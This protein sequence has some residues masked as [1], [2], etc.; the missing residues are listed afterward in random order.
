MFDRYMKTWT[1]HIDSVSNE[2]NKPLQGVRDSDS[3]GVETPIMRMTWMGWIEVLGAHYAE[4]TVEKSAVQLRGKM[5][6]LGFSDDHLFRK[7]YVDF[8]E[9]VFIDC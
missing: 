3:P 4:A 9:G 5:L 7:T 8:D 6:D 1:S 2:T